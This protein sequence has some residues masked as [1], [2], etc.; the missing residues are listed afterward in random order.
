MTI[1][2]PFSAPAD[3]LLN[4]LRILRSETTGPLVIGIGGGECSG[5]SYLSEHLRS[6][7]VDRGLTFHVI[8]LDGYLRYSRAQR[9]AVAKQRVGIEAVAYEIGD[10]PDCFDLQQV[11]ADIK[12]LCRTNTINKNRRYDYNLGQ[13]IT[14][15]EKTLVEPEA[16]V[17][18]EGMFALHEML[19]DMYRF[20]CFLEADI[21]ILVKR[22]IQRHAGRGETNEESIKQRFL[23]VVWPC[24]K[25][26]IEP[27][28]K[29]ASVVIS[30]S[31]DLAPD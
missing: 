11:R 7:S 24:Y 16:I 27:S 21:S 30:T 6:R 4:R 23:G 10:H 29:S 18:V 25:M 14:S 1:L 20:S 5:K 15:E 8:P 28:R 12:E 2:H 31:S 22:Y 13:V 9:K 17:I 19:V 3:D 26:F